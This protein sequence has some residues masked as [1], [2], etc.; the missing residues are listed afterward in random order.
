MSQLATTAAAAAA[1]VA[2]GNSGNAP[3]HIRTGIYFSGAL[4]FKRVQKKN[5]RRRIGE[6]E[7]GTIGLTETDSSCYRHHP[8]ILL[9]YIGIWT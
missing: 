8:H 6:E 4:K 1:A 9:V 3:T 2:S 5:R 7:G